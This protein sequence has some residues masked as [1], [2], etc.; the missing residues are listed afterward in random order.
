MSADLQWSIIRKNSSFLVKRSGLTLSAE[1]LNL[2]NQHSFKF[3]G[4][5]N[6]KAVGVQKAKDGKITLLIKN[7]RRAFAAQP[8]KAVQSI[9]LARNQAN[10]SNAAAKAIKALTADSYVRGDLTRFAIARYHALKRA[11]SVAVPLPK[12][13]LRGRKAVK[14]A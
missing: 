11:K 10:K 1:P 3:S 8:R 14:K 5:A 4:L 7:G 12:K 2:T 9:V 13:K 6:T